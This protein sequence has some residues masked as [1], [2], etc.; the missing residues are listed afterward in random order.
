[1]TQCLPMI[2]Y[3][4]DVYYSTNDNEIQVCTCSN[5]NSLTRT[6]E[7]IKLYYNLWEGNVYDT[8]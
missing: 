1:M 7:K 2:K 5:Y 8:F 3:V 4:I 6:H